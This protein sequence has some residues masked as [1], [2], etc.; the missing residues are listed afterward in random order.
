MKRQRVRGALL[1]ILLFLIGLP[2]LNRFGRSPVDVNGL[3]ECRLADP[4]RRNTITISDPEDL[5]RLVVHPLRGARLSKA[6][7]FAGA[8]AGWWEF[9]KA[10]GSAE[11]GHLLCVGPQG[12][13]LYRDR[14]VEADLS[15]IAEL[16]AEQERDGKWGPGGMLLNYH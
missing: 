8:V 11:S 2:L 10:D 14:I 1:A 6:Q 13:L 12:C 15:G 16:I 7:A 5:R 4:A 3:T 9:R